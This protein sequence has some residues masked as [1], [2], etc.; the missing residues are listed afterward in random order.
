MRKSSM[1]R[2]PRVKLNFVEL[3]MKLLEEPTRAGDEGKPSI[4][5]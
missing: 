5:M 4:I 1:V 2:F 3:R